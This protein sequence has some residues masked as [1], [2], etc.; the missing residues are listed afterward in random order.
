MFSPDFECKISKTFLFGQILLYSLAK[1]YFLIWPNF[2]LLF[3]QK[4]AF[5]F[6]KYVLTN[7]FLK[8]ITL[9][10]HYLCL[11][12]FFCENIGQYLQKSKILLY[13]CSNSITFIFSFL[14]CGICNPIGALIYV[15]SAI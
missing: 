13:Y 8:F 12:Y 14:S 1:I 4:T 2:T 6:R 5:V 11:S 3:G 7:F 9:Y 10:F 15:G